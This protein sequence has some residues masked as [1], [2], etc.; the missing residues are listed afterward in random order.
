S[1]LNPGSYGFGDE[2]D[3]GRRFQQCRRADSKSKWKLAPRAP[4]RM[5]DRLLSLYHSLPPWMRSLAASLRGRQ[6]RR[7][8]YGADAEQLV[9]EALV[10][11]HWSVERL[12]KW[13]EERLAFILH[14]AATKVP[15]YREHWA[16]RRIRGDRSSWGY[17]E[18]WSLLEKESV[19]RDPHAF[20]AEDCDRRRMIHERTSGT[21]GKPLDLWLR[22]QT[23]RAW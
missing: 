14:R 23:A 4:S 13:Q 15:F 5:N 11:E 6:L 16:R 2:I 17:L 21:T 1:I 7:W 12:R 3:G 18:N 19:R 10:R 22:S 9:D 8:R 20:L